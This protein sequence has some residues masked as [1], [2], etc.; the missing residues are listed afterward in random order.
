MSDESLFIFLLYVKVFLKSF[1]IAR[2]ARF[3]LQSQFSVLENNGSEQFGWATQDKL[4]KC[5][6]ILSIEENSNYLTACKYI[7]VIKP[8]HS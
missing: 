1:A 4:Q 2:Q 6:D 5:E 7:K 3:A 8:T